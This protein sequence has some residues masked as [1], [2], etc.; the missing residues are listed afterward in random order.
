MSSAAIVV[1]GR[2]A[3]A[4]SRWRIPGMVLVWLLLSWFGTGTAGAIETGGDPVLRLAVERDY[5]PFV[6][7]DTLGVPQGLSMDM[8]AL[9]QKQTSL[10]IVPQT[11]KPL[12][13][14]LQELRSGQVDL[15]TSLRATPERAQYLAFSHPY[16]EVPAILVLSPKAPGRARKHGLSAMSGLPV[17]VGKGYGVEGPMR[18]AYPSVQWQAVNDDASALHGVVSG[19]YAGAVADAA[20]V[21]FLV[22]RDGLHQLRPAGRVGFEYPLSFAVARRHAHLIPHINQAIHDI[23]VS[24]RQAVIQQWIGALDLRTFSRHPAWIPWTGGVLISLGLLLMASWWWL[25]PRQADAT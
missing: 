3:G 23:P 15:I 8:L 4:L 19:R 5:A 18:S 11:G 12:S 24:N 6:F 14:L 22:R 20:S 9:V 16:V 2:P 13:T 7:V 21:A 1:S 25:R 10:Q 17:A